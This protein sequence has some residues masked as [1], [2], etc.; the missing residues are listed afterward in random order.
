[1]HRI[2]LQEN[3]TSESQGFELPPDDDGSVFKMPRRRDVP[4]WVEGSF[5]SDATSLDDLGRLMNL[6]LDRVS[7]LERYRSSC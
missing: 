4:K 3:F 2:N 5:A 6:L 1:M 7:K